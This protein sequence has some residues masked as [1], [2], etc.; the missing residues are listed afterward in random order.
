MKITLRVFTTDDSKQSQLFSLFT[1]PQ[2]EGEIISRFVG[3]LKENFPGNEFQVIKIS[4][5]RYNVLALP[6]KCLQ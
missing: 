1:S 3:H 2:L 5:K 6:L 4:K